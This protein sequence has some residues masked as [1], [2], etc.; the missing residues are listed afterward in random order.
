MKEITPSRL[1]GWLATGI[2]ALIASGGA[3][4]V[5]YVGLFLTIL[6]TGLSLFLIGLYRSWFRT[7]KVAEKMTKEDLGLLPLALIFAI[8]FCIMLLFVYLSPPK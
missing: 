8:S 2:L 7:R 3:L 4:A 6:L 5:G 1:D